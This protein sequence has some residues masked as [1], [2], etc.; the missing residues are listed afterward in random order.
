MTTSTV[1]TAQPFTT[2]LTIT[3]ALL[4]A[5]LAAQLRIVDLGVLPGANFSQAWAINERGEIA[6]SSGL[7]EGIQQHAVLWR[8]GAWIDLGTLPG[9]TYSLASDINKRGDV[10]GSSRGTIEN[11]RGVLWHEEQPIDLGTLPGGAYST[12]DAINDKGQ[13]AGTATDATGQLHLVRWDDEQMVDLGIMPSQG[14]FVTA[15]DGRGLIVGFA[16][17]PGGFQGFLWRDGG[18]SDLPPLNGSGFSLAYDIN[19]REWVVGYRARAQGRRTRHSGVEAC[20]R[21]LEPSPGERS[22]SPPA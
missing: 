18:F 14:S 11:T 19:S 7:S 21:I 8:D 22:A 5:P 3:V 6:G 12:A 20:R 16:D 1:S 2:I 9:H 10:V 4:V 15:I 13:I 17:H